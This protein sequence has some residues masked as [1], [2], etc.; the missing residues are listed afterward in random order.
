MCK[1]TKTLSMIAVGCM[2]MFSEGYA[3]EESVIKKKLTLEERV[4]VLNEKKEA[5]KEKHRARMEVRK[6]RFREKFESRIIDSY[7]LE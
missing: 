2:V 4:K 1:M 7:G 5:K 3:Q 6:E